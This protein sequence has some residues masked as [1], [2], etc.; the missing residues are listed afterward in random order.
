MNSRTHYWYLIC[1]IVQQAATILE[2]KIVNYSWL[3]DSIK[4]QKK[5]NE[6]DYQIN[7]SAKRN[8][9]PTSVGSEE[10]PLEKRVK[11]E[12]QSP[13]IAKAEETEELPDEKPNDSQ[14]ANDGALRALGNEME[15][16]EE[17]LGSGPIDSQKVDEGFAGR[18]NEENETEEP[19]DESPPKDGQK[20]K[21]RA[22][23]VPV[24]EVFAARNNGK[25]R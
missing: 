5:A 16:T 17:P 24:D 10:K 13:T 2:I 19:R 18:S 15:E 20:T 7:F 1:S 22:I 6:N 12:A 25:S 11:I 3:L 21:G 9:S 14:K 8:Q 23:Y 4:E